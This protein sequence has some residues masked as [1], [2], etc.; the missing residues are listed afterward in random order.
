MSQ[1]S[2]D[3]PTGRKAFKRENLSLAHF[4]SPRVTE[5]SEA[6]L[7]PTGL[8]WPRLAPAMSAAWRPERRQHQNVGFRCMGK[9]ML[10]EPRRSKSEDGSRR[11][12]PVRLAV[13]A[14][15]ATASV[16]PFEQTNQHKCRAGPWLAAWPSFSSWR[17]LSQRLVNRRTNGQT[18]TKADQWIAPQISMF[19]RRQL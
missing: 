16:C 14:A 1:V 12:S 18:D 19:I 6:R 9:A 10:A 4:P 8:T 5:W 17:E 13:V 2:Y 11:S 3:P 15:T 7:S